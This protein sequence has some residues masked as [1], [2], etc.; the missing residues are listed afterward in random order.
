MSV[1]VAYYSFG[2]SRA[3]KNWKNFMENVITLR[4]FGLV[5]KRQDQKRGGYDKKMDGAVV[6][7]SESTDKAR[8]ASFDYFDKMG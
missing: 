6:E 2:S 3:D 7:I 8:K 5:G 1:D 4:V